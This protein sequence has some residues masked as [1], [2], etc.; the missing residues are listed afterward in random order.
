MTERSSWTQNGIFSPTPNS[1]GSA[2]LA[3]TVDPP[4]TDSTPP[5]T[6][7]LHRPTWQPSPRSHLPKHK[8]P[9]S[10]RRSVKPRTIRSKAT[11]TCTT[12]PNLSSFISSVYSS[13]PSDSS[14]LHTLDIQRCTSASLTASLSKLETVSEEVYG[15][16]LDVASEFDKIQQGGR[17][18]YQFVEVKSLADSGASHHCSIFISKYLTIFN[19]FK[20]LISFD[21]AIPHVIPTEGTESLMITPNLSQSDTV[22]INII[23]EMQEWFS[24]YLIYSLKN[25]G[26]YLSG[27]NKTKNIINQLGGLKKWVE[28]SRQF[29][30]I[31]IN[32]IIE[33]IEEIE[34]R[35]V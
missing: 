8:P 31:S 21:E 24:L 30:N 23:K 19:E 13:S 5:V 29:S 6:P 9:C 22:F 27:F 14:S 32:K 12:S 1:S 10:P 33:C 3:L 2:R 20:E 18:V 28:N 15:N 17:L 7:Q 34:S 26:E 25:T 16:L 11:S 35:I 4:S